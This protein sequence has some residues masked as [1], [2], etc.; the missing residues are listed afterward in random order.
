[1]KIAKKILLWITGLVASIAALVVLL[2]VF[3]TLTPSSLSPEAVELNARAALLPTF[4]EN[5]YRLN[6]LL[7]PKD[8]DAVRYGRCLLD[9]S[10]AHR[11][12]RQAL[13]AKMPA[14]SDK[15]AYDAYWK[16]YRDRDAALM[17]GCLE[18]GVRVKMPT[19]LGDMRI[20]L[21]T[22]PAQWQALAA[23]EPEPLIVAR[24]EA[25]WAGG[26]RRLGFAVDAP[27]PPY[28]DLVQLERW[29]TARAVVAWQSGERSQAVAAWNRS[30]NDWVKSADDS[31]ISA[32]ISTAALSQTMIGMQHAVA[33]S[34]RIDDATADAA[35]AALAAIELM[36]RAVAATMLV[37]WLTMSQVVSSAPAQSAQFL[38]AGSDEPGWFARTLDNAGSATFDVNDTLN[39]MALDN[40]HTIRSDAF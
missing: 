6:G 3:Y 37:E 26:P 8:V 15:A 12:E 13:A 32:M 29:R 19:A 14:S 38:W 30:V 25:I 27:L 10:N 22:E 16:Q 23:V 33:S 20:K 1:M 4:T 5:G 35:V 18:G 17:V 31:L 40:R 39:L 24:A 28:Q 11:T 2:Q 9:A 34:D 21:G 36:P 7:A